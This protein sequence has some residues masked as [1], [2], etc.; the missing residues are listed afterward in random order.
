[1][2]SRGEG[3]IIK[4]IKKH[5]DKGG[6]SYSSFLWTSFNPFMILLPEHDILEM[7]S[8]EFVKHLVDWIGS[9]NVHAFDQNIAG[10]LLSHKLSGS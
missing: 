3:G 6:T 5:G 8:S 10:T 7:N 2:W 9:L 4:L 1:M